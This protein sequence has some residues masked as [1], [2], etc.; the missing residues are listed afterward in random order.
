MKIFKT[1]CYIKPKDSITE[2][3]KGL[4]ITKD[5]EEDYIETPCVIL[6]NKV[7]CFYEIEPNECMVYFDDTTSINII[8]PYKELLEAYEN[9]NTCTD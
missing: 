8:S 4:G 2:H 3:L 1:K 5:I 6:L 7:N 9:F